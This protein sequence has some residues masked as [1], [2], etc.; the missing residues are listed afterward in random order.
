MA[1]TIHIS[2]EGVWPDLKDKQ[3]QGK[4]VQTD[5]IEVTAIANGT[6]AGRPAVGFRVELP[7]GQTVFAQMTMRELFGVVTAFRARYGDI[8]R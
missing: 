1:V 8:D 7:D 3:A 6:V 2:G 5:H 4:L